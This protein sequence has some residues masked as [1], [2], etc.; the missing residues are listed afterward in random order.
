MLFSG[1]AKFATVSH[2]TPASWHVWSVRIMGPPR[3][4]RRPGN[5]EILKGINVC[6]GLFLDM[7]C[8]AA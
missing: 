1:S 3:E 6:L 2:G 7:R 5:K 8:D 4:S